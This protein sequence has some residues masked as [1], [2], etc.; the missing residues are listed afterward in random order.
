MVGLYI[1]LF[2]ILILL[3]IGGYLSWNKILSNDRGVYFFILAFLILFCI[4]SREVDGMIGFYIY[5]LLYLFIIPL[6][7]SI[8][9]I[10]GKIEKYNANFQKRMEIKREKEAVKKAKQERIEKEKFI[11][12]K[13]RQIKRENAHI[14]EQIKRYKELQKQTTCTVVTLKPCRKITSLF[15]MLDSASAKELTKLLSGYENIAKEKSDIESAVNNLSKLYR[16]IGN[17]TEE[18]RLEC[19]LR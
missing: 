8:N 13:T 12:E 10:K 2:V 4:V 15:G 19:I 1:V 9:S 6:S 5:T 7:I 14:D 16:D 3:L 11:A 18:N 17:Y